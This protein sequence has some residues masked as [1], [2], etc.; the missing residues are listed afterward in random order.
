MAS[1]RKQ[2]SSV[3][4]HGTGRAH[5]RQELVDGWFHRFFLFLNLSKK[6]IPIVAW[7]ATAVIQLKQTLAQCTANTT[8]LAGLSPQAMLL[9]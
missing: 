9:A 5:L 7:Q 1:F 2:Q 3:N 8:P 6:D 4:N